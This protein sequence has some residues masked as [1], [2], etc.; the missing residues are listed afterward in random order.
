[1]D[2]LC[3][4]EIPVPVPHEPP[5]RCLV[6]VLTADLQHTALCPC[7]ICLDAQRARF[8]NVGFSFFLEDLTIYHPKGKSS[9]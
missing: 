5:V 8:Q 9:H 3:C 7:S 4:V 6:S 2:S 1:M